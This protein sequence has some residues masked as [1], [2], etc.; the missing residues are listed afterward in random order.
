MRM[1]GACAGRKQP[2]TT[3]ISAVRSTPIA[4][5]PRDPMNKPIDLT[6]P[7]VTT[8]RKVRAMLLGDRIDTSGLERTD[9]LSTTPLAFR[10]GHDGLVTVF[11]YGVVVLFGLS[12]LEEDE[13]LRGLR[14]RIVRP[15][16]QRED[17]TATIEIAPDKDE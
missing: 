9:V 1:S 7:P 15:I 16:E 6:S 11:R 14:S 5:Q 17:E 2:A 8:R 4:T 3:G 10:A 12:V 13:V